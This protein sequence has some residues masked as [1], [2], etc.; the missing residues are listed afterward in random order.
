MGGVKYERLPIFCYWCGM[1]DH[2]ETDCMQWMHSKESLR[3]EEKQ[4]GLWLRA[5]PDCVQKPQLVIASKYEG[6]K[7][8]K[9]KEGE[10]LTTAQSFRRHGSGLIQ[11]GRW[12]QMFY[13]VHKGVMTWLS[14]GRRWLHQ[15]R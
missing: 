11:G 7:E 6:R 15:R 5:T 10:E 13:K 4:Y 3:A 9:E 1:I 2:D 14:V 12:W 8:Y